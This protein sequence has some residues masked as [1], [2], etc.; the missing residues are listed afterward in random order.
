MKEEIPE[1]HC[2]PSQDPL[3]SIFLGVNVPQAM[4]APSVLPVAEVGN[5]GFFFFPFNFHCDGLNGEF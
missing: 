4:G 1:S 5:A 2:P 3:E